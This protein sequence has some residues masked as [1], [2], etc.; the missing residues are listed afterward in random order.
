MASNKKIDRAL[1][2]PGVVEITLGVVLS[3]TL[4]VLLG[5]LHLIFKPVE[6]VEKPVDGAK[7]GQVYF[8]QGS[9]NSGKARQWTRKRQMLTDGGSVDMA[10]NEEELNA[11]ASNLMPQASPQKG[12]DTSGS[13]FTPE[14]VNFRISDDVMQVGLLG[15]ISQFGFEQEMVFQTRGK[16]EPGP[17]GFRFSPDELYVGS[18]PVHRVPGLAPWLIQRIIT[19]QE[20]PENVKE[21]WSKIK[22]VAVEGNTLRIVTP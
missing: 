17:D 4:G 6:T 16:F 10:F 5:V 1:N 7:A 2:G 20:L 19:A 18:L 15:Q 14:K 9:V 13:I 3:L 8:V 12:A 21:T 22:L 11:W